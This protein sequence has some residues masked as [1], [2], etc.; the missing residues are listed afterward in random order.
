MSEQRSAGGAPG[1][2]AG[3]PAREPSGG[4]AVT[5]SARPAG[6][7]GAAL[8]PGAAATPPTRPFEA[9]QFTPAI[10]P[11]SEPEV[12]AALDELGLA[13]RSLSAALDDMTESAQA[14]MDIPAHIRRNPVKAAAVAG[15]AGFLVVGGPR[16]L[17]RAMGKRVVPRRRDAYQGLLPEEIRKILRESGVPREAEIEAALE[18]DFAEYLRRKGKVQEKQPPNAV[19]SFWRTYDVLV[20]P[21]GKAGAH[22][23]VE[24]ILA[25]EHASRTGSPPPGEGG[26][27]I[28]RG[29]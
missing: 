23:L 24:R 28:S 13:R 4:P 18:A 10:P 14:A 17:L 2:A 16:R 29:S 9:P 1:Q 26:T 22:T 3:G 20:G 6:S 15:G 8:A 21:L 11:G 27:I 12:V 5:R 7:P 25:A 19:R